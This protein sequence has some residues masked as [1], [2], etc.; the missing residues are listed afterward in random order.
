[1]RRDRAGNRSRSNALL[2]ACGIFP[3]KKKITRTSR[4]YLCFYVHTTRVLSGIRNAIVCVRACI[5]G[6]VEPGFFHPRYGARDLPPWGAAV[7]GGGACAPR[8]PVSNPFRTLDRGR[9][10]LLFLFKI[11]CYIFNVYINIHSIICLYIFR[12]YIFVSFLLVLI[13]KY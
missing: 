4:V 9:P 3:T 12:T 2:L 11:D 1:M 7:A 13:F 8:F 5:V 10:M 6:N